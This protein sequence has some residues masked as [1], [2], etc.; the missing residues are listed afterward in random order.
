MT[1]AI[2]TAPSNGTATV[3]GN[4]VVTYTHDGSETTS[5]S[6]TFTSSDGTLTSSAGTVTVTVAAVNDAPVISADTFTV[7]QFDE[8]T[9]DIPATDA[10]GNSLTFTV[11][12]D[13][14]Q[15]TL[16]DNGG[17]NFTYF[18]NS[19]SNQFT[20]GVA[21]DTFTIK[22]NDGS[23]DSADT[24]LTFTVSEIDTSIPQV[25]LTSSATSITETSD[26][27][28][29]LTVNAVLISN[30]FYSVRR[31]TNADP[32][33]IGSENSLGLIYVGESNGKK[34]YVSRNEC[35]DNNTDNGYESYSTAA[36]AAKNFG[37]YLAVFETQVEQ[38]NVHDLLDA[39]SLSG[40]Y[41]IGPI[42]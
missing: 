6:F 28:A 2:A 9:F 24:V 41:W 31:D 13:P 40:S 25:L 10:E 15:G 4:G 34:Y 23:L 26:G 1:F 22:A 27:S 37:G 16:L 5:D 33:S 36:T 14:S 30:D 32:V 20:S 42:Q 12:A 19:A 18:N 38:E 39:A 3:D 7:D 8:L 21:T 11:E 17:G 29:T 35:C